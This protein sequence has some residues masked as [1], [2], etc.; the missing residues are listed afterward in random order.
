MNTDSLLIIR[1]LNLMRSI[2]VMWLKYEE[3]FSK[4]HKTQ[5]L[6]QGR[7]AAHR[8]NEPHKTMNFFYINKQ[9]ITDR[10]ATSGPETHPMGRQCR[11]LGWWESTAVWN[12]V[13]SSRVGNTGFPWEP[14]PRNTFQGPQETELTHKILPF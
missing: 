3:S 5:F 12:S 10:N 4:H 9:H 13:A 1:R 6:P 11:E 14:F 8:G 7:R 2:I